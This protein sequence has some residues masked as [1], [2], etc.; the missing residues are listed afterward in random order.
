MHTCS[1]LQSYDTEIVKKMYEK[2]MKNPIVP[3]LACVALNTAFS[4]ARRRFVKSMS[5]VEFNR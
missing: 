4:I 1:S 3:I 2:F 5:Q